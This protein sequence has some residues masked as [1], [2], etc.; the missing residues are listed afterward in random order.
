MQNDFSPPIPYTLG[1][2]AKSNSTD[3]FVPK[4]LDYV[5]ILTLQYFYIIG[6]Q[7]T[8]WCTSGV[9]HVFSSQGLDWP[10]T[11]NN[12]VWDVRRMKQ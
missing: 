5:Y 3:S 7:Q 2:S 9:Y 11:L 4:L 10:M 12:T 8:G 1:Y 6:S